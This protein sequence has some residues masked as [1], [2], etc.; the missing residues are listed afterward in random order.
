[1][2]NINAANGFSPV[3]SIVGASWAEKARLYVIPSTD[4]SQYGIGDVVLSLA[5]ADVNGVPNVIKATAS[6]I[7]RGVIVG[8][9]PVLTSGVS[10]AGTTLGLE[11]IAIPA[12]KTKAYYVMVVD[13]PNVIFEIQGSGT[14]TAAAS[15]NKNASPVIANP[16]T[17]SPFSGTQLDTGTLNTT[18]TLMLKIIGV[19]Q[20]PGTDFTANAKFLVKFNRHEFFGSTAGV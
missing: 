5:G 9:D 18:N 11:T 6:D 4:T 8:I 12:T 20:R 17:G 16:A 1:M 15:I 7:P 2:A 19:A 10:L 14:A 3:G 13:D